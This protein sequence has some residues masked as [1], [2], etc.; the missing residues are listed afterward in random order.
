MGATET[1]LAQFMREYPAADIP[2]EITHLAKRCVMNYCGVALYGSIDPAIDVLLDLFRSDGATEAATVL[3]KGFRT[4]PQNAALANGFIGHFEDFDDTH[5]TVI[6]PT[7]PIFPAPLALSELRPTTGRDLL[8]A[9]TL[10]VEVACRVGLLISQHFRDGAGGW[11]ITNTC[12]VIGAGAAAGRLLE[13]TQEQ[14]V[15]IFAVAGTQ[16]CGFREVFGSMCKPFHAGR[17]AQNGLVAASLVKRGF[18]GT[19]GI[20]TGDRGFVGVMAK[21]YDLSELTDSLGERWELPNVGLKPYSCGQANHA[22]LDAAIALGKKDGVRPETIQHVEGRLRSFAPNLV[23]HHHPVS[24]LDTKFSYYHGIAVGLLDGQAL[25]AQFT[26]EKAIDPVIHAVRAKT[27]VVEDPS[28]GRGGAVLTL[29]L[30]DGR[31]YT[32]RVEHATGTPE[33]P[34]SDRQVEEK[35]R[36]LALAVLPRDQVDRTTEMLWN[37]EKVSDA[38]ELAQL[39]VPPGK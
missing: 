11:H 13:L 21:D 24:A 10:G 32:E 29:T 26:D 17:A 18:T 25:P 1:K 22:L 3:G 8:A 35:F 12:G 34:M 20:F 28:V 23:R 31:T 37:L 6:H 4:S 19:D 2:P 38:R 16:A 27:E 5:S 9:F 33:N 15:W 39:L 14:M 36:G 7:S 30:A